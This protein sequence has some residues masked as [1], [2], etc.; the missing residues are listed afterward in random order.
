MAYYKKIIFISI[1]V[2]LSIFLFKS[3]CF[4]DD[5]LTN[6]I[7]LNDLPEFPYDFYNGDAG[8][9][10]D[11]FFIFIENNIYNLVA[12]TGSSYVNSVPGIKPVLSPGTWIY[13]YQYSSGNS[14]TRTNIYNQHNNAY[15]TI[16]SSRQFVYSNKDIYY[17]DGVTLFFKADVASSGLDMQFASASA[18]LTGIAQGINGSIE[19]EL[20]DYDV[21][22]MPDTLYLNIYKKEGYNYNIYSIP[23]YIYNQFPTYVTQAPLNEDLFLF[24]NKSK[25]YSMGVNFKSSDEFYLFLSDDVA[26]KGY[27]TWNNNGTGILLGNTFE[28][29]TASIYDESG[30][31]TIPTLTSEQE[32]NNQNLSDTQR[33]IDAINEQAQQQKE[34]ND[35]LK[36]DNVS[37]NNITL[38][39]IETNDTTE[40]GINNIFTAIYNG[41]TSGEASDIVLPFPFTNKSI[42]IPAY[43]TQ[44]YFT[45]S[46][47]SSIYSIIQAFY[48]YIIARFIIKDIA[49]KFEKIKSGNI[50]NLENNNIKTDML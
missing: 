29:T 47:F 8:Q 23:I 5:Y 31:I 11:S 7:N 38:P 12:W 45:T 9:P 27:T 24:V 44:Q 32:Q 39:S 6:S 33:Q 13:V 4:A 43:Y 18:N 26:P 35:F 17:E 46:A 30:L 37:D 21:N 19:V 22:Q 16:N 3:N 42:V 48:W 10:F 36:D 50:E 28:S 25:L 40:N 20:F 15:F 41:L 1:F 49:S 34:T 2:L 14:W